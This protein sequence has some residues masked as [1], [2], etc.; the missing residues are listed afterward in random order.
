MR[1]L[2]SLQLHIFFPELPIRTRITKLRPVGRRLERDLYWKRLGFQFCA[3]RLGGLETFPLSPGT[4]AAQVN[5]PSDDDTH[6]KKT[7]T[8]Y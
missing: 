4:P 5:Y 6:K 8:L 7:T 3:R 2:L 1:Q